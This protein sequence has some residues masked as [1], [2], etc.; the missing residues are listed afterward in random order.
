M[1]FPQL[2]ALDRPLPGLTCPRPSSSRSLSAGWLSARCETSA[3]VERSLEAARTRVRL[4]TA[5][6]LVPA[7]AATARDAATAHITRSG[8]PERALRGR[9]SEHLLKTQEGRG[10][11]RQLDLALIPSEPY[12][13]KMSFPEVCERWLAGT[14]QPQRERYVGVLESHRGTPSRIARAALTKADLG[15]SEEVLDELAL[16]VSKSPIFDLKPDGSG[17]MRANDGRKFAFDK[18]N[19]FR[20]SSRS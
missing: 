5:L 2:G 3:P 12:P 15:A 17:V 11:L 6:R 9:L 18:L 14:T 4:R 1:P 7:P 16:V 8:A 13:R 10:W 20:G 19:R